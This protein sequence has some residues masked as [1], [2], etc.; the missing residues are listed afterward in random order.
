MTDQLS[1]TDDAILF[2]SQRHPVLLFFPMK[3]WVLL[4]VSFLSVPVCTPHASLK[5][6]KIAD[7]ALKPPSVCNDSPP[8]ATRITRF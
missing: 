2:S 1:L 7:L 8:V 6:A 3:S 4:F 5:S